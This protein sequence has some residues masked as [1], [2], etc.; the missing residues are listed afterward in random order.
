M[1]VWSFSVFKDEENFRK[2]VFVTSLFFRLKD[3]DMLPDKYRI[4]D[5]DFFDSWT[6]EQH[7]QAIYG[8]SNAGILDKVLQKDI[9]EFRAD[10]AEPDQH[11][12]NQILPASDTTVQCP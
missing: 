12:D 6:Q 10:P 2:A 1:F 8:L 7:L 4:H 9:L 5:E 11:D 3:G